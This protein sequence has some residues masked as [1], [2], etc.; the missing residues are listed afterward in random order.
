MCVCRQVHHIHNKISFSSL[1][2]LPV[3][4]LAIAVGHNHSKRDTIVV[5]PFVVVEIL[6]AIIFSIPLFV[7]VVL[8]AIVLNYVTNGAI[9]GRKALHILNKVKFESGKYS[10]IWIIVDIFYFKLSK[11]NQPNERRLEGTDKQEARVTDSCFPNSATWILIIL[12]G[13][14]ILPL[15]YFCQCDPGHIR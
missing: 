11:Q 3:V 15:S 2:F 4:L 10:D 1:F 8:I 14:T 12:S 9:D 5:T 6:V 7:S 13:L